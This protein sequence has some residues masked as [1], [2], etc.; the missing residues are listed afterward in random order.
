MR[1]LNRSDNFFCGIDKVLRTIIP[2]SNR[3]IERDL[4]S[5]VPSEADAIL[6]KKE[7]RHIIGLMRVNH[8][9]E[10]CAQ[11]LYQGQALTAA[12][13]TVRMHM[14][15]AAAE[16]NDHLGWC[17]NR[18]DELGGSTSKLNPVWYFGSMA[19]GAGA[20]LLG[21]RYSLGFVAETEIQ[22]SLHLQKH[23]ALL[24]DK[25]SKTRLILEKMWLDEMRH[26]DTARNAG[27]VQLPLD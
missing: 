19:I 8:A 24:P 5:G 1:H 26:A 12:L 15:Q 18:L 22:V 9:G 4:F 11:G 25:D 13:N 7:K 16:E 14:E 10:V 27:G 23:L 17:E 3:P 21:D 6:T 20:G 2:L